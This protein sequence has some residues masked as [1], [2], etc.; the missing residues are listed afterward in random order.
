MSGRRWSLSL[1]Q[2]LVLLL[3][4]LAIIA[5]LIA[6][7][8]SG[9]DWF[10]PDPP[11]GES[12]E[13]EYVGHVM[14]ANT[15][16]PIANAKITLTL[17]GVPPVVYTDNEGIYRFKVV[18]Q[19][20]ISGQVRVDAQGYQVYIRDITISPAVNRIDDIRLSSV[21]AMISETVSLQSNGI[22]TITPTLALSNAI[23]TLNNFYS[24]INNAQNKDDLR[25]AWDLET[26]GPNG[27]QCR[28]ASGCQYSKFQDSWWLWKVQYKLYDC[29]SNLVD[30]ELRYYKRDPSIATAPTAPIY[31]RYQ[32]VEAAGELK[33]DKGQKIGS[34]GVDCTLVI[35]VP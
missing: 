29:G 1:N 32:L 12:R 21:E 3:A 35:S 23:L 5:T 20:E 24:W 10:T 16:Q 4:V 15:L 34:P 18:I 6:A 9:H 14:D 19:S 17:E 13:I 11:P 31:V 30:V 27:L 2:R 28:E 7:F 22:S 26:S 25:K 8:L 33:I